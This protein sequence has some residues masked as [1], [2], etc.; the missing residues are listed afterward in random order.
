MP[1]GLTKTKR[2][3]ASISSTQKITKA[4]EMVATVKLKRFRTAY[5][6]GEYYRRELAHILGEAFLRDE[7]SKSHYA[8]EN[9]SAPGKLVIL[10]TS[11]LGLCAGYNNNLYSYLKEVF[12]PRVD[13]LAIIGQKG[14]SH[15]E[16]EGGFSNMI[17]DFAGLDLSLDARLIRHA[18]DEVKNEFNSGKYRRI[19]V[20]YTRYVNSLKFVPTSAT[21]LPVE[22]DVETDP[23]EEYCPPLFEPAPRA[24][25]H[26]LLS[27][28]LATEIR[29]FLVEAQLSE[30]ASRRS[31]MES[32]NDN[33]DE[34]LEKLKIEYNKAR[35]A[36]ITQ[37]ITEV[38]NG[39][40]AQ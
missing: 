37:E 29:G 8:S 22:I 11:N 30:Q 12:D 16:R 7:E 3:I 21:L 40:S 13:S 24:M 14:I 27:L 33:A 25:I 39:A 32:A 19:E 4:M 20:V 38:V 28:Y 6:Q 10:I 1:S 2:R 5:E 35:Q 23:S 18:V 34:L 31:A 36:S 26:D 15:Y 9:A 17:T